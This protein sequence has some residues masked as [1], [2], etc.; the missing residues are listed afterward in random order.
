MKKYVVNVLGVL[1][2]VFAASMFNSI[3]AQQ[4]TIEEIKVS[5]ADG[6][7]D[8]RN[9]VVTN[10]DFDNPNYQDGIVDSDVRFEV[11]E[12]GEIINVHATSDCKFVARELEEVMNGLLYKVDVE[13]S[14]AKTG[15]TAFVMPVRLMIATR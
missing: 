4:N 6:F 14:Q 9:L 2:F 5:N 12:N 1:F 8:L 7:S 11:A 15:N 13:R 10:F 3:N